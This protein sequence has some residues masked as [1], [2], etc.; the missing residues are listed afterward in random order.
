MQLA[1]F[2]AKGEIDRMN[3]NP[4]TGCEEKFFCWGWSNESV[5][6]AQEVGRKYAAAAAATLDG[7]EKP[8]RYTYGDKALREKILKEWK[9]DDGTTYAA[10]TINAYGC[11]ILN[12]TNVFFVDV[13]TDGKSSRH[14]QEADALGRLDAVLATDSG[15]GARVYRTAA[16]LRYIVCKPGAA[17][18]DPAVKALMEAMGADPL[19][20]KLCRIQDCF[21]ARLTPKP[22]R[23]GSVQFNVKYPW[24]GTLAEPYVATWRAQYSR[25]AAAHATCEWIGLR[26][27]ETQMPAAMAELVALHD[28]AT[29]A[30]SGRPLA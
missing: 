11:D 25:L 13:D 12:T 3:I 18:R 22:W 7:G 10:V 28:E 8:A 5:E 16:G 24:E 9:T 15:L 14:Q 1:K 2:W 6:H 23:C 29:L 26:G 27:T 4:A 21:R 20:V 17:P 19:Y 30:T